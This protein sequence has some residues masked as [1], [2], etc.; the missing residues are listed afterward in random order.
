MSYGLEVLTSSGLVVLNDTHT[1]MRVV[2][3]GSMTVQSWA[4]GAYALSPQS[5]DDALFGSQNHMVAFSFPN[6]D[7]S[8]VV[9]AVTY[10]TVGVRGNLSGFTRFALQCPTARIGSVIDYVILS[11]DYS[12]ALS[13]GFGIQVRNV[14]GLVTFQSTERLFVPT[15]MAD[16]VSGNVLQRYQFAHGVPTGRKAYVLASSLLAQ[17]F[18]S[19]VSQHTY[20]HM[21]VNGLRDLDATNAGVAYDEFYDEFFYFSSPEMADRTDSSLVRSKF[22]M[23]YIA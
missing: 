5:V 15:L 16:V 18:R 11:T 1:L 8:H 13:Q 23:G 10:P 19:V 6:G 12:S 2:E 9:S 20:G 17:G 14:G 21:Y 3:E 7:W 22:V 4:G